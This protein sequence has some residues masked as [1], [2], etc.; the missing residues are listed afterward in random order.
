MEIYTL[1]NITRRELVE[2]PSPA[3]G[4][5]LEGR[6]E[7]SMVHLDDCATVG[8]KSI[9][10]SYEPLWPRSCRSSAPRVT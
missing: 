4:W 6:K 5:L 8:C 9:Q 1:S 10:F 3:R 7:G 2:H